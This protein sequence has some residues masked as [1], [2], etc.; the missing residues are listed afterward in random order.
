VPA[1]SITLHREQWRARRA[2]LLEVLRYGAV[3]AA[4]LVVDAA[5]LKAL[6]AEAG[7]HY[8]PASGVSFIAGCLSPV[9]TVRVSFPT[10]KEPHVGVCYLIAIGLVGLIVNAAARPAECSI[11]DTEWWVFNARERVFRPSTCVTKCR[12]PHDVSRATFWCPACPFA[13]SCSF[14]NRKIPL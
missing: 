3:S 12:G 9:R 2:I 1:L 14:C 5:I 4:A 10:S 13:T 8:L 7:W 11:W 6:V